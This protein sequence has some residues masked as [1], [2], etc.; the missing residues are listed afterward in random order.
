M[1]STQEVCHIVNIPVCIGSIQSISKDILSRISQPSNQG[2]YVCVA[3][4]HMLS[5]AHMDPKF[6]M[7]MESATLTIADGMPLVWTQKIKGYTKAERVSGP[8]LMLELCR[9]ASEQMQSIYLLG[10]STNTLSLLSKKL[11]LQFPHLKIAGTFS[12]G[13]LSIDPSLDLD[14]AE[15]I[16]SSGATLLF[17]GLGCPKQEFWCAK[18]APH[19]KPLAIGVGAAFD[20]H[21]GTKKRPSL[22]IQNAG[23]EW[24]YRLL[25]EPK[26]L[27]RRYITSNTHFLFLSLKEFLLYSINFNK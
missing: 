7:V 22:F 2:G 4:A 10:S 23:F 21:A 24:L 5:E 1:K 3:N 13:P 17:V 6:R 15:K 11:E 9:L 18:Y 19:L 20:F 25:C 12:P 26:R 14:L 16:N 8:D 27:G